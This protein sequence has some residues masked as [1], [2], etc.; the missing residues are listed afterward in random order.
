MTA[1]GGT[2][3]SAANSGG[4][5]GIGGGNSKSGGTVNITGGSVTATGG[6]MAAGIGGGSNSGGNGGTV[7]ISGSAVVKAT[8]GQ[9]RTV[10]G[11]D[12]AVGI[13][14]G[15]HSASP[16]ELGI[17]SSR[18][19]YGDRT[20]DLDINVN[21]AN[22]ILSGEVSSYSGNRSRYM[23]VNGNHAH[24][25]TYTA[26]GAIVTATCSIAGCTLPDGMVDLTIVAPAHAV[27]ADG[28]DAAATLDGLDDFNAATGKTLTATDM[29]YVGRDGTAYAESATAPTDAGKYTAKTTVENVIARVD[30]KIAKATASLSYAKTSLTKTYGDAAFTNPLTNESKAPVAYESSN[31][32]V[33]T[34][35]KSGKVTIKGTGTATITA[36]YAG[37]DTHAAASASYKLTVNK[38]AVAL[39]YAKTSLAK[40][41]G[42]AAFTNPLTNKSKV[43]VTYKSSNT[44]VA[45]VDKSGKVT[46]KGAGT[47]KITATYAGDDTHAAASASYELTVNKAAVALK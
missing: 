7:G 47:A 33:A 42:D 9:Y 41:V 16:G 25:F 44:K 29:R 28:K 1:R 20:N 39:K 34:V 13:G 2:Y 36:P 43:A 6:A 38:A 30:Y 40:S 17:G 24:K 8:G 46:I 27:Y 23:V 15:C 37:D 21:D 18:W 26:S 12:T 14:G 22:Y 11:T 5:A 4:G 32:K 31:A 35:D 3:T 19:L 10:V 45:A